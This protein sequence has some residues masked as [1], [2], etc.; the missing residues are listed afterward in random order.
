MKRADSEF[1][2]KWKERI[3]IHQTLLTTVAGVDYHLRQISEGT[4]M[5]ITKWNN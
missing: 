3:T 2:P 1:S 5:I 4:K